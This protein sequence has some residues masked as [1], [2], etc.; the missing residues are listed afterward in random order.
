MNPSI[1]ATK[2]ALSLVESTE[3]TAAC[4]KT[5]IGI[6]HARL[7]EY[8]DIGQLP[9][10]VQSAYITGLQALVAG[11]EEKEADLM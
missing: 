6:L 2:S 10:P 1:Q 5:L 3:S 11:L 8:T 9:C 7:V 4:I